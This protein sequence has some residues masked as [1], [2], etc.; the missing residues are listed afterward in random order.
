[1]T[2]DDRIGGRSRT[3]EGV[4]AGDAD[5]EVELD[6]VLALYLGRDDFSSV[7]IEDVLLG[8]LGHD[9]KLDLLR[10]VLRRHSIN[11]QPYDRLAADLAE[12][13][14]FRNVLAHT[15][16]REDDPWQR[17]RRR[18]GV[19]ELVVITED[20]VIR[21]L[22]AAMGC[23]SAVHLLPAYLREHPAVDPPGSPLPFD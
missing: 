20:E 14:R 8:R 15:V 9:K 23:Q 4:L 11:F 22:V 5:C 6:Y 18:A 1:M 2:D 16:S 19:N 3:P 21:Q 12:L 10:K 13:R 17:V 7:L